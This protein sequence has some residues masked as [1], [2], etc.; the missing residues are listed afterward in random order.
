MYS[1]SFILFAILI[2]PGC[3][4]QGNEA[5][6]QTDGCADG[7]VWREAFAG[8]R[9]CVGK[10][11]REL[12]A[13]ENQ[14]AERHRKRDGG[15]ECDPGFVW[16]MAGSQDHV[17]V[18]QL[19]RDQAQQ[20]N[21]LAS[22]RTG[23]ALATGTPPVERPGLG[24]NART[25]P[26]KPG[27]FKYQNGEWQETPCT[28]E[29]YVRRNFPP[30]IPPYSIK[31]NQRILIFSK[32]SFPYRMPLRVASVRLSHLSDPSVATLT[33]SL[34]GKDAFSIQV[35]TNFFPLN[36]GDTG[37]VQFVLQ[38][39]PNKNDQLCVW[40][41]DVTTQNYY[42]PTCTTVPK[43]R[44][45][46]GPGNPYPAGGQQTTFVGIGADIGET[47]EV[48]GILDDT[49]SD[50]VTRLTA[51]A[52]VPWAPFTAYAVTTLDTVGLRGRWTEISGDILGLGNGSQANFTR[53]KL[54]NE[55][56]ASSCVFGQCPDASLGTLEKY[57][58]SSLQ[59]VTA[60]TS[61]LNSYYDF[62]PH[63]P[64]LTCAQQTCTLDYSEGPFFRR[65]I[66]K[67]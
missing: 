6:A 58:S 14:N 42:T 62:N 59:G 41:W 63:T 38:S 60:E 7:Y 50:G 8:D 53:T 52:Y 37:W 43:E 67:E 35:N 4:S 28:S 57:A 55:I 46:F 34:A 20:D 66:V 30:P 10:E 47:S 45:V 31:S 26:R 65:Y 61:N 54:K 40:R 22:G 5:F 21:N 11:T 51:W 17:C 24:V 15:E 29:E 16:R 2:V 39:Q 36:N 18:T 3:L 12:V 25:P 33:D 13:D 19:E 56:E 48:A 32:P 1:R 27:C 44:F 64:V 23:S 49:Q 9:V